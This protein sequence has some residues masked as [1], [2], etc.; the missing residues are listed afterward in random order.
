M[1]NN[2]EASGSND[3]PERDFSMYDN[4]SNHLQVIVLEQKL[5][6]VENEHKRDLARVTQE[7][8]GIQQRIH[9][10]QAQQW[11]ATENN[12]PA[13]LITIT[14]DLQAQEHK[15][16]INRSAMRIMTREFSRFQ[17]QVREK[18]TELNVLEQMHSR[19]EGEFQ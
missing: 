10:L 19:R 12:D 2:H 14:D 8:V 15:L 7:N 13:L 4:L 9:L 3:P 17:R 1:S 18:I 16:Q 5:A 6:N 11:S